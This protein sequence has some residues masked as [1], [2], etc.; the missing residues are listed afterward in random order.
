[1]GLFQVGVTSELVKSW[2]AS[3]APCGLW[4]QLAKP[5]QLLN[6]E[7]CLEKEGSSGIVFSSGYLRDSSV[8]IL[9]SRSHCSLPSLWR[10]TRVLGQR[11]LK[12]PTSF[13]LVLYKSN[14]FIKAPW[15]HGRRTCLRLL[16]C[17]VRW[18]WT[19]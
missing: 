12:G 18:P 13:K 10:V 5:S 9:H 19:Q 7:H 1:M 16:K 15:S 6:P 4:D 3:L 14:L 17:K 11:L 2:E 8:T